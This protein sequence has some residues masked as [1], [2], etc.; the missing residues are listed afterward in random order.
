M[1]EGIKAAADKVYSV[2]PKKFVRLVIWIKQAE[3]N[4]WGKESIIKAL[5][6]FLPYAPFVSKDW[7]AYL[8]KLILLADKKLNAAEHEARHRQEKEA[9]REYTRKM[10]E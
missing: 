1:D 2:N 4:K 6:D 7:W 8:D 9:Q 5:D 3:K 10:F